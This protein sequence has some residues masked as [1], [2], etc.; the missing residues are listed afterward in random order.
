MSQF[1]VRGDREGKLGSHCKECKRT[2]NAEWYRNNKAKHSQKA[3]KNKKIYRKENKKVLFA[4]KS[5]GCLTCGEREHCALDAHHLDPKIKEGNIA[6]VA[7]DSS[8]TRMLKE[9]NKCV[10]LCANCHRKV[11]AGIL[12]LPSDR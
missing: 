3:L 11:H 12:E 2:Y 1:S 5:F 9:L 6:H 10:C 4:F 7:R 8:P